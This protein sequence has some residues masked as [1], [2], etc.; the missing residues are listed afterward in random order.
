[1][2]ETNTLIAAYENFTLKGKNDNTGVKL[3]PVTP[4]PEKLYYAPSWEEPEGEKGKV[5][6]LSKMGP[7]QFQVWN[8][9]G[10]KLICAGNFWQKGEHFFKLQISNLEPGRKYG[11]EVSGTGYGNY[12]GAEL[13]KGILMQ[14]GALRWQFIKVGKE[15]KVEFSAAEL[16]KLLKER[17]PAIKAAVAWEK[18]QYKRISGYAA[19]ENPVVDYKSIKSVSNAGVTV[20][21]ADSALTVTTPFYTLTVEPG[22]GGRI[23]N[24]KAGNDLFIAKRRTFGFAVAGVWYPAK[25]ALQLRSGM[26]LEGIVPVSDGVEVRLSR[27][28]TVKDKAALAGVRF[29]IIHKFTTKGVAAT[30][31]ITN[32]LHDAIELSFRYHNMP[33]I[34]GNQKN[35]SGS[36]KFNSG[37]IFHRDLDQKLIRLSANDPLL[38]QAFKIIKQTRVAKELPVTLYA[39]WNKKALQ[40]TF[41]AMPQSIVVWDNAAQDCPS[42]EPIYKRT[43]IVPGKSAEFIMSAA[44]VEKP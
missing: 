1:M 19:A 34:L 35:S 14:C 5:P 26:K 6:G 18:A 38:E 7:I 41:P 31:K 20:A 16:E 22:Q 4:L 43:Q 15:V 25:N 32:L 29:D 40:I 42:F 24:W 36:I 17:T 3:S 11:V 9:N 8:H 2:A 37:E 10:E 30:T 13:A 44:V 33:A 28:L 27:I 23:H 39:P 12:T 21:A